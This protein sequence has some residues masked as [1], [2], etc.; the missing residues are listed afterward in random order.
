MKVE[1]QLRTIAMDFWASLEH[2]IRYKKDFDF[3]EEMAKELLDCA[4][5]S[6]QLD[7]RMD[8][9]RNHVQMKEPQDQQK[10]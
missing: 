1:I 9:L 3:T 8:M 10:E 5:L 7:Y 4:H 6:A 2:Q